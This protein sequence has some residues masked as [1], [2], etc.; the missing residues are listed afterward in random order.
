MDG[1]FL[2]V[3]RKEILPKNLWTRLMNENKLFIAS[4]QDLA[5][6]VCNCPF[7]HIGLRSF[8]EV[9]WEG[10]E[11]DPAILVIRHGGVHLIQ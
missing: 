8:C 1:Y 3:V 5:E 11:G 7:L 10:S 6:W 9:P 4:F 2:M